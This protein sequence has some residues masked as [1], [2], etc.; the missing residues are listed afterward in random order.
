MHGGLTWTRASNYWSLADT[1]QLSPQGWRQLQTTGPTRSAITMVPWFDSGD[2][3]FFGG[4]L[5]NKNT[6]GFTSI[7]NDLWVFRGRTGT[8]SKITPSSTTMPVARADYQAAYDSKRRRILIFGGF[9]DWYKAVY[10]DFWELR[11]V[12]TGPMLSTSVSGISISKGGNVAF[13][14]NGGASLAGR[15]YLLMGT[16]SGTQNRWNLGSVTVPLALDFYTLYTVLYPNSPVLV[17]SMG[18]LNG[19]GA[20]QATLRVFPNLFSSSLIGRRV[21]HAYIVFGPLSIG[22]AAASNPVPLLLGP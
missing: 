5:V 14:L 6:G 17:N 15:L 3:A 9:Q 4:G 18:R 20:A 19:N 11:P 16:M 8:W 12:R 1:W 22:L 10:G 2:V 21:H 13:S 7:Y